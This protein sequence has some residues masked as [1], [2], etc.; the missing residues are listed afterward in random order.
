MNYE[1]NR[2]HKGNHNISFCDGHVE[3]IRATKL[4]ADEPEIRR[5]WC[6]DDKPHSKP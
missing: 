4:W 3:T 6:Y 2:C 1:T 5:R